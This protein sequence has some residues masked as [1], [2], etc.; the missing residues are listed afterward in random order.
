MAMGVVFE[1]ARMGIRVPEDLSVIGIDDH[2]FSA[3]VGLTTVRQNPE[4][5]GQLGIRML[6]DE[7]QGRP[8]AV[9]SMVSP[10]ELIV[11]ETTG[12]PPG[13]PADTPA[14]TAPGT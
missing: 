8:G 10:H 4:E 11:R 9:H 12:P 1:A 7:L 14:G 5:Q 6:V 3:A 2:E 13:R